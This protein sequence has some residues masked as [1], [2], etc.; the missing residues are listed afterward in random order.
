MK[1]RIIQFGTGNFLRGFADAFIDKMNKDGL[2][3]GG[4]VIVSPTDSK[5]TDVIN[6]QKGRYNLFLRGIENGKTV[7]R[8]Y[9]IDAVKRA[10][11]PYRDFDGFLKLADNEN[12]RFIITNTTEAGITFDENCKFTDKPAASFPAKLTQLLFRRFEN[13]LDGFVILAC[14]LIDSN[15]AELK[16][17]VLEY[18]KLWDL[19]GGFIEFVNGKN[20]FCN[21]LVD[22]I[23][24]GYPKDEAAELISEI[25]WDDKLLDTAE[26][27]HFWAIEGNFE[28]ELPLKAAGLNVIWTDNISFYKK[29][30]VRVLNG[31]HTS[32]VF[33]S[34]LC[35]IET[36]GQSLADG[37]INEF[38]KDNLF[39]C[40]LPV[41]GESEENLAF[42]YAVLE[43]FANPFIKHRWESIALNSI[44]KFSV[45]VLPTMLDFKEKYGF[46][47]KTMCLSLAAL[48]KY[49]KLNEISDDKA[50]AEF[51]KHNGLNEI[52]ANHDL[53]GA[54][55]SDM[56]EPVKEAYGFE[57][58]RK[59]ITW[60]L[61]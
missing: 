16:K 9:E 7:N 2:F 39:K 43:R 58:M 49:Y 11:N 59:A 45:R 12:F 19:G 37:Q 15:G 57:D 10:V 30:K 54:D 34:L 28:S 27:Y 36:V 13:R 3:N 52:L 56:S 26:P 41:L 42:A 55:L 25:G 20:C 44:S 46:Y 18:A 1:E 38:L 24:T 31:T 6:S 61:S 35:G 53:W 47:P 21:T 14:E 33:V 40:I 32:G 48:I 5:N 50:K 22:R 17:C 23:V 4:V 60:S 51:I 29:R 8:R